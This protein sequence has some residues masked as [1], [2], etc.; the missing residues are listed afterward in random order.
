MRK[1]KRV[2]KLTALSLSLL[3]A[4]LQFY[5]IPE[6]FYRDELSATPLE[7]DSL[8]VIDITAQSYSSTSQINRTPASNDSHEKPI[9]KVNPPSIENKNL[10]LTVL[11]EESTDVFNLLPDRYLPD[12]K[13]FCWFDDLEQF[14]C[15]ASVYLAGMPKCGTTD[16]FEKL[17]W[18][19]ELT[20]QNH[21]HDRSLDKEFH[22]WT[23]KRIGRPANFLLNPRIPFPKMD[24]RTFLAGTGAANVK[25]NK[26]L[27][28]VDGTPS[29]LWDL[30]GWETRYA[31][32]R[33]PPYSNGDLIHSVTPDAK[34]LAI[35]R[36]PI[37]RLY[38]E[39]LYVWHMVKMRD[40][41]RNPKTFHLDV[42]RE[43]RKF[44]RCL[45]KQSLRYCCYSSDHSMRLRVALGVYVCY[46]KDF[47][48][49]FGSNLLVL[50]TNE[51][52]SNPV[53]TLN[54]IFDHIGVYK[55]DSEFLKRKI[56]STETFNE[57]SSV[58]K[59][60]GEMLNETRQLLEKFYTPYN[61]M[62]DSLLR[63]SKFRFL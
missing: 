12:Y 7:E 25:I 16:L 31:G 15:L 8:P 36:N 5:S 26:D 44:D 11:Y 14:Q 34:I 51:Y 43:T 22:Y 45:E 42:M 19:P 46:I 30:G 9:F 32:F 35:L 17:M 27:R 33:E 61:A 62:L 55:L 39:Y 21:S 52:Q 4:V 60:V 28:I 38:S 49:A 53:V 10:N 13:S 58:R 20:L 3:I 2:A 6:Y 56:E 54:K 63:D 47:L 37:D 59:V 41:I 1:A 48:E 29:L 24:F 57:G 50:T 18:H 23:R 40:E